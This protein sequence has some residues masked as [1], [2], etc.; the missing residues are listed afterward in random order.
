[1]KT[2]EDPGFNGAN[3]HKERCLAAHSLS[4]VFRWKRALWAYLGSTMHALPNP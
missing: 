1:M 3:I 2:A 4:A